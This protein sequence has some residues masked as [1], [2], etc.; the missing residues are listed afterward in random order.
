MQLLP[1]L[2]MADPFGSFPHS[3]PTMDTNYPKLEEI[4]L[5][6]GGGPQFLNSVGGPESGGSGG[7]NPSGDG[8]EHSFEHLAA[9]RQKHVP[10]VGDG[11]DSAGSSRPSALQ[12]GI[13]LSRG[14]GGGDAPVCVT[15]SGPGLLRLEGCQ[16]LPDV[17]QRRSAPLDEGDGPLETRAPGSARP[18]GKPRLS[19]ACRARGD[20]G[21]HPAGD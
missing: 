1:S 13:P 8:G 21:R 2:Q 12:Q 20:W 16:A 10:R 14:S 9:G 4:M 5:L 7:F 17:V 18:E 15:H 6:A 11:T 19:E 3:P